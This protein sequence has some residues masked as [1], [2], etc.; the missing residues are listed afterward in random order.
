MVEQT[1]RRLSSFIGEGGANEVTAFRWLR[2]SSIHAVADFDTGHWVMFIWAGLWTDWAT[3]RDKW[4]FRFRG[5]DHHN[6]AAM[7]DRLTD[8]STTDPTARPSAVAVIAID[9]WAAQVAVDI[10][11]PYVGQWKL[12]VFTAD[13]DLSRDFVFRPTPRFVDRTRRSE[14]SATEASGGFSVPSA[15]REQARLRRGDH[16]GR[17]AR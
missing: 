2:S 1:Y 3:M 9:N 15:Y 13:H 10:L 6:R 7:Y 11:T 5:L 16:R 14:R 8:N 12:R 4:Q 17:V